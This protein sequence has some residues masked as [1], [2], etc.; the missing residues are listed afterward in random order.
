M[1][2]I[3]LDASRFAKGDPRDVNHFHR[4][5]GTRGKVEASVGTLAL[6]SDGTATIME[7]ATGKVLAFSS[8]DEARAYALAM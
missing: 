6:Y 2:R 1:A 8:H 7:D 4:I 3:G 5:I